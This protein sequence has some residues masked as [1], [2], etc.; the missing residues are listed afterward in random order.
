MW[1]PITTTQHPLWGSIRR[2]WSGQGRT[3]YPQA[4]R[5][6]ITADVGGSNTF[7]TPGLDART[8][9][10]DGPA[11]PSQNPGFRKSHTRSGTTLSYLTPSQPASADA[12]PASP[13]PNRSW[14]PSLI[15]GSRRPHNPSPPY[16]IAAAPPR[17]APC[18]WPESSTFCPCSSASR[19]RTSR[20]ALKEQ[21]SL[22]RVACGWQWVKAAVR[23][24]VANQRSGA[25][26]N[27][28]YVRTYA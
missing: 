9:P 25:W 17:T 18:A 6:L 1:T 19:G 8:R 16:L 26:N 2:R 15:H 14:Q 28:G 5:R 11:A 24:L 27:G 3:T 23:P 20:G 4:T 13:A 22:R 10:G 7:R 12:R 21:I